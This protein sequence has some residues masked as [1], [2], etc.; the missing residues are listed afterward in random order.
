MSGDFNE[1]VPYASVP[2]S[3]SPNRT[4]LKR[5]TAAA[6]IAPARSRSLPAVGWSNHLA[7]RAVFFH[8]V[9]ISFGHINSPSFLFAVS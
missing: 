8:Y 7:S 5:T 1:T 3:P 4:W 2:L 6:P 9:Q